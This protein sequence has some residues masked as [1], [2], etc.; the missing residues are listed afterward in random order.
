MGFVKHSGQYDFW[1]GYDTNFIQCVMCVCERKS[2][3]EETRRHLYYLIKVSQISYRVFKQQE[4]IFDSYPD[5]SLNARSDSQI[6]KWKCG[7]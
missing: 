3:A 4:N 5:G 1:T 7:S 2:H 6:L